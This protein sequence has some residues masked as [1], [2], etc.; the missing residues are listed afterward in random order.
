[1]TVDIGNKCVHCKEDT[2]FG[3]GKFVN[4][5][6]VFGL[7][8]N[9]TGTEYDGYCCDECEQE[10]YDEEKYHIGIS[11]LE[12]NDKECIEEAKEIFK[13]CYKEGKINKKRY[14]E[15]IIDCVNEQKRIQQTIPSTT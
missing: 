10:W 9:G 5:Y 11:R 7:D 8:P 4:M 3:S 1:M 14:K 13:E 6:P 15:L 2:S 12:S